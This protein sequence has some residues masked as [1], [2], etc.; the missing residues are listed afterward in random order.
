M[1]QGMNPNEAKMKHELVS[2]AQAALGLAMAS[3]VFVGISGT[4]YKLIAPDGWIA[5]AFGR[6]LS[7]GSA[8]LGALALLAACAWYSHGSP[9]RRNLLSDIVVYGFAAA[10]FIYLARFLLQGSV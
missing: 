10:G 7:A 2:L 8:T 1:A 4:I 5:Q 9:R 6:S 3:L